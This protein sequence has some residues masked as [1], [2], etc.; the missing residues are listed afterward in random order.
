MKPTSGHATPKR[1][2]PIKPQTHGGGVVP[3]PGWPSTSP[4]KSPSK[5][6]T[7]E[8]ATVNIGVD[9]TGSMTPSSFRGSK[10]G[11]MDSKASGRLNLLH[12][13]DYESGVGS[14]AHPSL[15]NS[16]LNTGANTPYFEEGGVTPHHLMSQEPSRR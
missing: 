14:T 13:E 10:R 16:M 7:K 8:T 3:A 15:V 1:L 6:S 4:S 12:V 2:S 11:S 5:R 9:G